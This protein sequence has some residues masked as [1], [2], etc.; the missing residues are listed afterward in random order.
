MT[1]RTVEGGLNAVLLC[2]VSKSLWGQGMECGG[3]NKNGPHKP[4]P[5]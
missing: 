2:D 3:L 1:M 5:A 4:P